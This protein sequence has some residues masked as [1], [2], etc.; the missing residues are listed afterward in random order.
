[1]RIRLKFAIQTCVKGM[2]PGPLDSGTPQQ[3]RLS[4]GSDYQSE[5]MDM[6]ILP[7]KYA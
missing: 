2:L 5:L 7:I 1:M 3:R 6:G 4:Q